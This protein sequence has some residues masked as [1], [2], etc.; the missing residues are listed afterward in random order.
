VLLV[1]QRPGNANV[2]FATIE[3]ETGTANVVIW[4]ALQDRFR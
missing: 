4:P 3:D 1:R 2:V